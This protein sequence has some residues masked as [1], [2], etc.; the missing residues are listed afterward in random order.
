MDEKHLLVFSAKWCGPCRMMRQYVWDTEEIKSELDGFTSVNF[1]DID[2]PNNRNIVMT[3]RISAVPTI[4]IVNGKGLP[5]KSASTMNL[6]Q[7]ISFLK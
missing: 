1:L 4:H 2:D 6:N 5:I 7:T 3:Y